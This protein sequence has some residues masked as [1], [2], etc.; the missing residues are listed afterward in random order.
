MRGRIGAGAGMMG[1]I[2]AGAPDKQKIIGQ[3]LVVSVTEPSTLP[4]IGLGLGGLILV[5]RRRQ[6]LQIEG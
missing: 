6:R 5:R 3:W 2:I 4:L 1:N